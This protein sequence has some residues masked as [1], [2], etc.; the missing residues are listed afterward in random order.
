MAFVAYDSLINS[1]SLRLSLLMAAVISCFAIALVGFFDDLLVRKKMELNSS[2]AVE[3]RVG[4]PQWAKPLLTLVGA[5]PLMAVE[6]GRTAVNLPFLGTLDV[7]LIYPLVLVPIAVAFVSNASNMLAGFNGLESGMLAVAIAGVGAWSLV[8]GNVAGSV[9]AFVGFGSIL[10]FWLFN[11][12]PARMLPG[13]SFTYFAGAVLVS[14]TILGGV[15]KFAAIA[16][17]PWIIEFFLKLRGRFAVRSYGN[18]RP[19]GTIE[20]PYE[21]VYSLP[22]LVIKLFQR[23]GRHIDEEG[24][25]SALIVTEIAFIALASVLAG[26]SI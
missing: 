6:A 7:G 14:A 1:S 5:V 16:F 25:A 11:C 23:L 13:D 10:A 18:L 19:D 21:K 17:I 2:G 26:V 9:V 4:L 15:E 22:H 8:H 24:V 12:Y 3:Y 20:A